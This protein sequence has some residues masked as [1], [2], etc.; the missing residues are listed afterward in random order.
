VRTDATISG[1]S[2]LWLVE[3]ASQL[4]WWFTT[5]GDPAV[6]IETMPADQ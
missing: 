2:A 6:Q 5:N 3:P 4:R 1:S